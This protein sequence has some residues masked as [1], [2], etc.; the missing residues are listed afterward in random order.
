[1]TEV[2][3]TRSKDG[4][5]ATRPGS[6]RFE[7]GKT[8][9][10]PIR[11]LHQGQRRVPH[12][13]AG[14]MTA[15]DQPLCFRISLAKPGPSTHEPYYNKPTQ[16]GLFAHFRTIAQSTGLPI[17]L[18]DVPSRTACGL[19]DETVVRLAETPQFIGLKGRHRRCYPAGTAEV[20]C[21]A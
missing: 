5:G 18:Y 16:K 21:R 11:E 7:R 15:P 4:V 10:D 19:A 8:D 14:H 12:Q 13:Q 9:W 17:I 3:A 6:T 1:M 2:M 20:A